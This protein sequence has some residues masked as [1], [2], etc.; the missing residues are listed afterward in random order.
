[1]RYAP[2][3]QKALAYFPVVPATVEFVDFSENVTF[4][5]R[6]QDTQSDYVLRLHRP[7]YNSLT[8]LES[9]REWVSALVDC[10]IPVPEP[11]RTINGKHFVSIDI[12]GSDEQRYVGMTT[13][14]EGVPL[15]RCPEVY[16]DPGQRR[17]ILRR[18]GEITADMHNQAVSWEVPAAFT[19]PS[20]D[21][22]GLLGETPRWGRFWEHTA[23][24]P[25]GREQLLEARD[26]LRGLLSAYG[27]GPHNY[28]LIHADLDSDNIIYDEGDLALI[29]FDDSAYG[30]HAYDIA[31][32]LIEYCADP[33]FDELQTA[34]L[35]GYRERRS[36]AV[37]DEKMLPD[38]LLVRGLAIVGWYHDRPE[39]AASR[40]FEMI[41]DW[42]LERCGSMQD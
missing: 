12:P 41:R 21:L 15:Y 19:R 16:S 23:L 31:S 2:A 20:L 25:G 27:R 4:R 11:V 3:V 35:E 13:W 8:E 32:A 5:I 24:P 28:S 26:K 17:R 30:W 1:M 10:G 18:I 40:D 34:M 42:T 36:F 14:R 9:E 22:D 37:T 7:G 38:F 29:D 39:Y 6:E 33:D